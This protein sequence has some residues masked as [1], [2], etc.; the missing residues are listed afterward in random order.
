M[1]RRKITSRK[2]GKILKI[3][4]FNRTEHIKRSPTCGF[5]TGFYKTYYKEETRLASFKNWYKD[6]KYTKIEIEENLILN[7]FRPCP[8]SFVATPDKLASAGFFLCPRDEYLDRSVC[9]CCGL[10]LVRWESQD[11]P[12]FIHSKF[13]LK[14]NSNQTN[15]IIFH[16]TEHQN[17]SKICPFV[18]GGDTGNVPIFGRFFQFIY[19]K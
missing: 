1:V 6:I 8:G 4:K 2:K 7:F 5:T 12:W 11:D 9:F 14:N 16:R 13:H 18:N 3:K 17:H 10:A 15:Y 19:L